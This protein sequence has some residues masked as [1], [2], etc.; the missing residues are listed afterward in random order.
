[1]YMSMKE[2][3]IRDGS[4]GVERLYSRLTNAQKNIIDELRK[5]KDLYIL[6]DEDGYLLMDGDTG[7]HYLNEETV[8]KLLQ[9]EF[10]VFVAPSHSNIIRYNVDAWT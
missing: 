2:L 1:M 9:Q 4:N 3:T 5:N 6:K 10:L 7:S 8:E